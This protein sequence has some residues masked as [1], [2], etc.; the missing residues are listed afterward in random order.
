MLGLQNL[1]SM[2]LADMYR[3]H[4]ALVRSSLDGLRERLSQEQSDVVEQAFGGIDM[5]NVPCNFSVRGTSE[6]GSEL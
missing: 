3:Q 4:P 2:I 1:T 6:T 5:R